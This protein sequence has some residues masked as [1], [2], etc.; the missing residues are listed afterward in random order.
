MARKLREPNYHD[1]QG[2]GDKVFLQVCRTVELML[3]TLDL[4]VQSLF[5]LAVK[6]IQSEFEIY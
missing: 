5:F 6:R 3:D 2:W 1:W 4:A